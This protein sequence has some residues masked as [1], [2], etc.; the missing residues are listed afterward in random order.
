MTQQVLNTK[1]N[2]SGDSVMGTT[3]NVSELITGQSVVPV[4][5]IENE[6]Q[7]MGLAQALI[8]GGVNVIEITLRNSFGVKAIEIIKREFPDMV[9]LAGTVNTA[10]QMVAVVKAGVDGII[11]PGLTSELLETAKRQN[12]PYLPGVATPSEVLTA[13]EHGLTECKLFPATVVGGISALKAFN[14]P[15]P[16]MKFCPTGGVSPDNYKD[17]LALPNVMCVGGSWIAPTG[18]VRSGD[19]PA[20]IDLCKQVTGK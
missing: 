7:A 1:L 6:E 15:F 19:W 3:V 4:V 9:V 10:A 2:Q 12:I 14:G 17:F 20:I 13:I 5:V 8:D 11:S 16:N 18:L